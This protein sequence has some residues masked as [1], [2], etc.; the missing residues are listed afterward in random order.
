MKVTDVISREKEIITDV[1]ELTGAN[2]ESEV[3][4]LC[5]GIHPKNDGS[6]LQEIVLALKAT[7]R[8]NNLKY[9]S[10]VQIGYRKRVICIRYDKNDFR[11]YVNPAI[12]SATGFNTVIEECASIPGKKFL[13]PRFDSLKIVFMTP[14]GELKEGGVYGMAAH[15]FQH[16]IGHLNGEYIADYGLEIDDAWST[17]T[18]DERAE[19]IKL[20]LESLDVCFPQ[21]KEEIDSDENLKQIY[22]AS[23]FLTSVE[24]G[25]TSME[26]PMLEKL[27]DEE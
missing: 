18:D 12:V 19:I 23:K 7:M 13:V 6:L 11:T 10:A 2:L 9:L 17:F 4:S 24:S 25:E 27:K 8:K 1:D 26:N 15:L 22:D 20:Y 14:L 16:A 21:L 3:D 5:E